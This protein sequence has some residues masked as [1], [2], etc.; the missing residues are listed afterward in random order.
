MT[1]AVEFRSIS[2]QFGAVQANAGV[3]FAVRKGSIHGIVGE[4]GAGKSTLMSIL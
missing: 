2:K 4:N 1:P 3:S